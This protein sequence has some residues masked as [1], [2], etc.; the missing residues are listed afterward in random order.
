M[1]EKE[2]GVNSVADGKVGHPAVVVVGKA[3]SC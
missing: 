3:I 1:K 2:T